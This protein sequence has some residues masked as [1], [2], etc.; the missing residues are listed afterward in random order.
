MDNGRLHKEMKELQE[1][2]KNVQLKFSH[3]SVFSF[4]APILTRIV[5]SWTQRVS[6]VGWRQHQ[7]LEWNHIWTSKLIISCS[8]SLLFKSQRDRENHFSRSFMLLSVVIFGQ[9]LFCV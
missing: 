6:I 9:K 3:K 7:T 1:A 4:S 2:A 5:G 8:D